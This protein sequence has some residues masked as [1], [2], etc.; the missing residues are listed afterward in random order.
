MI[1]RYPKR[2]GGFNAMSVL[3]FV[4]SG[5]LLYAGGNAFVY[6]QLPEQ[7]AILYIGFLVS[8][9]LGWSWRRY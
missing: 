8:F 4:I 9:G 2:K 3:F 1:T 6:H 7:A 5:M